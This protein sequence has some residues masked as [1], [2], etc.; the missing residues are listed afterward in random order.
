MKKTCK[1]LVVL[2]SAAMMAVAPGMNFE[3]QRKALPDMADGWDFLYQ[4]IART[5]AAFSPDSISLAVLLFVALWACRRYLFCKPAQTGVGEY[6]LCG[7]M[8]GMMLLNRGIRAGDSLRLLYANGFQVIKSGLYLAGMF[9][10]FLM[11]LRGLNA[12][13]NGMEGPAGARPLQG[14][15]K[16]LTFW[17]V[18]ALLAAAWL[19]HVLVKYPGVLMWDTFHQIKQFIGDYARKS[20]HPPLGTLLYGAAAQAG[21]ALGNINLAYFALTLV[22]TGAFL[23]VLANSLVVM[24]RMGVHPW[25]MLGTLGLYAISPCY[26]GWTTVICKDTMY[27]IL[28]MQIGV[29]LLE[30]A[31]AGPAFLRRTKKLVWLGVCFALLWLTRHN[32]VLIVGLVCAAI[33]VMLLVEKQE[34][35]LWLRLAALGAAVVLAGMGGSEAL[36]RLLKVEKVY[37]HDV[38][39]LPFQQTARIVK[40]H[41][42]EIPQEEVQVIDRVLDYGAIGENYD[43]WYADAVKDTYRFEATAGDR[44]AYFGVWVKQLARYPVDNLDAL[45][46]MNGVLFDLQF[47]RPMYISLSDSAL[48]DYVYP[49]AYNDMTLY[50]RE[51]I[52]PLSSAQRMLTQ[53]YFSF[54][55]L[56][57][58][59]WFASMGFC[60]NVMLALMYLAWVNGRKRALFVWLPSIATALGCLFSP[61]VY[62]RYGLPYVCALPLWFAAYQAMGPRPALQETPAH[63]IAK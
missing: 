14:L 23:A 36:I 52:A 35:Q 55:R 27:L 2:F 40:L 24:K 46:H 51:E 30:L 7:F 53:W 62:L 38:F 21:M 60:M 29:F 22:Q 25:V 10:I 17:K 59:G 54:E 44:G 33:A 45:L 13:L 11:A 26:V 48:T 43:P 5:A 61:V 4:V 37:M 16:R 8:A 6:L 57:F 18:F 50:R 41:G 31:L 15:V 49:Y 58:V 47:N 34:K 63:T 42:E 39:S 3:V 28:C 32:G 12:W 19:P 1:N 56:P 9:L 20:N